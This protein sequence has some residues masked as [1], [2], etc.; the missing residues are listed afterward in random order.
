MADDLANRLREAPCQSDLGVK[1]FGRAA[2][3]ICNASGT[4]RKLRRWL[5]ARVAATGTPCGDVFVLLVAAAGH[6]TAA[7]AVSVARDRRG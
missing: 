1:R 4:L 3:R 2:A 5:S 6:Q 7:F